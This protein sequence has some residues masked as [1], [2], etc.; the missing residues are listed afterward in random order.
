MRTTEAAVQ[1]SGKCRFRIAGIGTGMLA[2]VFPH[3]KQQRESAGN[4]H[5]EKSRQTGGDIVGYIV[6]T[7]RETAEPTI[8][9]IPIPYHGVECIYH[10]IGK[11]PRHTQQHIPEQRSDYAVAQVLCQRL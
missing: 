4:R 6:Q 10:L 9:F 3:K 11:H 7:C 8:A 1:Y 2:A 5:H